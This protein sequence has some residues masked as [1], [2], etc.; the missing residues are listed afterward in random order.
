MQIT[1]HVIDSP[2]SPMRDSTKRVLRSLNL[3]DSQAFSRA[4]ILDA[5]RNATPPIDASVRM[6]VDM[7]LAQIEEAERLGKVKINPWPANRLASPDWAETRRF[8][9]PRQALRA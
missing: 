7:E 3:S 5:M 8:T 2:D 4:E 1:A 6:G 9:S